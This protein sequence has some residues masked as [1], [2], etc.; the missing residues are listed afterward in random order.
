MACFCFLRD[1]IS[2]SVAR[3]AGYGT[4]VDSSL[5]YSAL[6]AAVV[7]LIVSLGSIPC[8]IDDL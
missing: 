8:E 7:R 1:G 4:A 5:Y 3:S 6:P 2:L